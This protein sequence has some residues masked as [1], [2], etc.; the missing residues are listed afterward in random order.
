L[1]DLPDAPRPAA[2][3]PAPVR[4]LPEWDNVLVG[5]AD[6]RLIARE[7][8]PSVFRPGLRVLA[9]VLV[10]GMVAG[11]WQVERRR[12][13]ATLA[14][15]LFARVA[16]R[17]RQEIEAEATRLLAFSEPDAASREVSIG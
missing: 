6:A 16:P 14:V 3:E 13:V 5:R 12:K 11:T 4:L 1:F 7:H 2:D 15:S 9:T 17:V 8:R 10:D